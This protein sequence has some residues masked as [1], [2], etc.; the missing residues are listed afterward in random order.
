MEGWLFVQW[1]RGASKRVGGL[2]ITAN[3]SGSCPSAGKRPSSLARRLWFV[4]R[5]RVG[6]TGCWT[7]IA[8]QHLMHDRMQ[9]EAV[10]AAQ[11]DNCK[12][13][14]FNWVQR[15]WR[16]IY[17]CVRCRESTGGRGAPKTLLSKNILRCFWAI[18]TEI[19]SWEAA[20]KYDPGVPLVSDRLSRLSLAVIFNICL[21]IEI[22][23]QGKLRGARP[24]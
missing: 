21:W 14:C 8:L 10:S 16:L 24:K 1:G 9:E 11:I 18:R 20:W 3:D 7:L 4:Q 12:K 13:K 6:G 19:V 2:F 17:L 23:H 5:H 22:L 15:H